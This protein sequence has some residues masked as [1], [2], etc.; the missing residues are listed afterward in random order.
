MGGGVKNLTGATKS[1]SNFPLDEFVLL[2]TLEKNPNP[3]VQGIDLFTEML[4]HPIG[5]VL[6]S[7][8]PIAMQPKKAA[9]FIQ[10]DL[11]MR[12][13]EL[14]QNVFQKKWMLEFG[15]EKDNE[16]FTV[17]LP[18]DI[19]F[20]NELEKIE[21][22]SRQIFRFQV[23]LDRSCSNFFPLGFLPELTGFDHPFVGEVNEDKSE[24]EKDPETQQGAVPDLW[25][26]DVCP[27]YRRCNYAH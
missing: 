18:P 1:L 22:L 19:F 2:Q 25:Q 24:N 20:G 21:L 26:S 17:L 16:A 11:V 23:R 10:F 8:V 12:P 15:F 9:N 14:W 13:F 4:C 27:L 7:Q 5:D 3:F 6:D